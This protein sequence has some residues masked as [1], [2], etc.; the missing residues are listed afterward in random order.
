MNYKHLKELFCWQERKH[1]ETHLTG[2]ITF[3]SFGPNSN[4]QDYPWCSRT[5]V[6]SSANKA[7]QPD[8]GGYSIFGS[9]LDGTDQ[10]VRLSEVM[11]DE[12]GGKD[13]WVVENCFLVGYLLIECCDTGESMVKL[14]YT[15]NSA[16]DEMISQLALFRDLDAEQLKADYSTG[17]VSDK[18]GEYAADR[19]TAFLADGCENW[20]WNIHHVYI[21]DLLNIVFPDLQGDIG[22]IGKGLQIAF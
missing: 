5:Y 12:H 3:S 6:I 2:C 9:C 16:A 21:Y 8:K 22:D 14:F 1:P 18:D 20:F 11:R 7:F 13:G 17:K 4:K 15:H 19:S 10:N